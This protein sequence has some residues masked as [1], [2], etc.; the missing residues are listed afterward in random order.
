MGA[1]NEFKPRELI[2]KNGLVTNIQGGGWLNL[3]KGQV[4]D[5]TQMMF[6]VIKSLSK[7]KN[8]YLFKEYCADL[9][10]DWLQ[11]GPLD[12]GGQCYKSIIYYASYKMFIPIQKDSLGNGSLMRALPCAIIGDKLKNIHQGRITHNNPTCDMYIR[13]YTKVIQGILKKGNVNY[14]C[15]LKKPLMAPTGCV[16]NTFNNAIYWANQPSFKRCIFGAVNDGG[17]S[18]TIAAIAGGISGARFGFDSIPKEW[19]NEL[20]PEVRNNIEKSVNILMKFIN[21]R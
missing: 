18:D 20:N 13:M 14:L 15:E 21:N 9:F 12:V 4:T 3:P 19:V 10:L 8:L 17:D 7:Y 5:D 11:S 1:T 16:I 6:M 2:L